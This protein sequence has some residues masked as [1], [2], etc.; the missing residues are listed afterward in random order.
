MDI[1]HAPPV[2]GS[3]FPSIHL[4]LGSPDSFFFWQRVVLDALSA[5]GELSVVVERV[6]GGSLYLPTFHRKSPLSTVLA[7]P[8]LG[9]RDAVGQFIFCRKGASASSSCCIGAPGFEV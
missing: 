8:P 4:R 9:H 6:P 2:N 7:L 1:T 5:L 3:H